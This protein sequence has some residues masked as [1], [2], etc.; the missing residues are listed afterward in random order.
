MIKIFGKSQVS[1][2]SPGESSSA[3][4]PGIPGDAVRGANLTTRR[5][6]AQRLFGGFAA[7]GLARL[8]DGQK[9]DPRKLMQQVE[10]QM[11]DMQRNGDSILIID[12]KYPGM[13]QDT[14][15]ALMQQ[16]RGILEQIGSDTDLRRYDAAASDQIRIGVFCNVFRKAVY[17][18]TAAATSNNPLPEMVTRPFW[19]KLLA[20]LNITGVEEV[21]D[22]ARVLTG[23]R[24][25]APSL[26]G[27][28]KL[29]D[30]GLAH[31]RGLIASFLSED[32]AVQFDQATS[33]IAKTKLLLDALDKILDTTPVPC[34]GVLFFNDMPIDGGAPARG[35]GGVGWLESV[36]GESD[37]RVATF[38]RMPRADKD[39]L[40]T[41][42]LKKCLQD[43]RAAMDDTSGLALEK[44]LNSYR[45]KDD[46]QS[47]VRD[48][49]GG[50]TFADQ[51]AVRRASAVM[52]ESWR[53]AY[54]L[55][56]GTT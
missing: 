25:K 17:D 50:Q 40:L 46:D 13:E 7:L 54:F 5:Q 33:P 44:Y 45:D 21:Q 12:M 3:P 31:A 30:Q 52:N 9:P 48:A 39:R 18:L 38:P 4:P 27:S 24:A 2:G 22:A 47:S 41:E 56:L 15:P 26:K 1:T 37:S 43:G 28:G 8:A 53:L 29:A 42:A 6:W 36:Y 49:F 19:Q 11:R 10:Q 16:R 55:V 32:A 14:T 34:N 35:S 51:Q 23:N 20:K